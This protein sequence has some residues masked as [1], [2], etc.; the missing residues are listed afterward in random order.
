MNFGRMRH[1]I[2]LMK[3]NGTTRNSMN[4]EVPAYEVYHPGLKLLVVFET[5]DES[6]HVYW[7]TKDNGNAD[8]QEDRT[9]H[10]Y[11]HQ[12]EESEWA[13]WAEVRPTTGRSYEEMQK[14]RAETTYN[15]YMRYIPGVTHDMFITHGDK[16]L[17]I[18]SVIDVDNRHTILN[19]VCSEV[20][21]Q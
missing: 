7:R 20:E 1:R 5:N 9:G 3:R 15:V 19:L 6:G 17:K 2:L 16:K 18:E 14:I 21:R 12:L 8:L 11:A 4:E 10:P 13:F